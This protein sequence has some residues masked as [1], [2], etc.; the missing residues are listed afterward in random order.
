MSNLFKQIQQ[1]NIEELIN[2]ALNHLGQ[3]AG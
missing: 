2:F 3:H 1:M